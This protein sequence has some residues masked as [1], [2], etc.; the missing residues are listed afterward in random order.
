MCDGEIDSN[1]KMRIISCSTSFGQKST[2][3]DSED[4]DEDVDGT[5]KDIKKTGKNLARIL[6]QAVL[7]LDRDSVQ[8]AATK[9]NQDAYPRQSNGYAQQRGVG[10][11]YIC[12]N[13]NEKGHHKSVC[14]LERQTDTVRQKN[15]AVNFEGKARQARQ[16][17][18]AYYSTIPEEGRGYRSPY[19]SDAQSHSMMI[20]VPDLKETAHQ[21]NTSSRTTKKKT[22]IV[23]RKKAPGT[24]RA[25]RRSE[26]D[27]ETQ[28]NM[29]VDEEVQIVTPGEE[30]S[31]E[32]GSERLDPGHGNAK[33]VEQRAEEEG[34]RGKAQSKAISA[35]AHQ[36]PFPG[37]DVEDERE[38][39]N[40]DELKAM[41]GTAVGYA[42]LDPEAM[43]EGVVFGH[44]KAIP[45][46]REMWLGYV[47]GYAGG[48][49][50]DKI[51]IDGGSNIELVS[52]SFAADIRLPVYRMSQ[53][54]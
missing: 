12:W 24:T 6:K 51:M 47:S 42:A 10:P 3:D 17:A 21:A 9:T 7:T 23:L 39:I 26:G 22:R 14:P 18:N 53:A 52:P 19:I 37:Q 2:F 35:R 31:A 48:H 30:V 44:P 25:Q 27:E 8:A 38:E 20:M 1:L 34:R 46:I 13:C 29:E 15:R 54:L 5:G 43:E 36:G 40:K 41:T 49:S 45:A 4:E 28:E 32:T 33:G 11:S 50:T 16:Q